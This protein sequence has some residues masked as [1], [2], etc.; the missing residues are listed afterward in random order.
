MGATIDIAK[1]IKNALLRNGLETANYVRDAAID[2]EVET[3]II[4]HDPGQSLLSSLWMQ[5]K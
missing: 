5:I 2:K 1:W 4:G 3:E